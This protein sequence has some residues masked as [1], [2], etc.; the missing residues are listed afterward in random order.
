VSFAAAISDPSRKDVVVAI[1]GASAALGGFVLVFLGIL[2]SAY[3][4][5]PAD[6]AKSVKER[7]RRAVWPVLAVFSLSIAGIAIALCW[8][9]VPGGPC[10]YRAVVVVFAAELAAIVAV[11][12]HTTVRMLN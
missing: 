4:A 3:Q 1:L 5:Y 2:I 10:L 12:I 7:R 9:T 8:L 6:T 11:A